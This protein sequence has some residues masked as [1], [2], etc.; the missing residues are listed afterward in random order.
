MSNTS[1]KEIT[2][3][4][5][6]CKVDPC[7]V[8]TFYYTNHKGKFGLRQ[9]E[10]KSLDWGVTAWFPGEPQW[11]LTAYDVGKA[12][13]RTFALSNVCGDVANTIEAIKRLGETARKAVADGCTC[14][15]LNGCLCDHPE[16][17]RRVDAEMNHAILVCKQKF[18]AGVRENVFPAETRPFHCGDCGARL[19][20]IGVAEV[21]EVACTQCGT[22]WLVGARRKG[23]ADLT[24]VWLP[25]MRAVANH[26]DT[27]VFASRLHEPGFATLRRIYEEF[28]K[29]PALA[30]VAPSF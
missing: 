10:P 15:I 2:L 11:H 14:D 13:D 29:L 22:V 25:V 12:A 30:R 9:V 3:S 7:K 18:T 17:L 26:I 21:A 1:K 24:D 6:D 4:V 28:T 23:Q 8:I 5:G 16:R 19:R 20:D 27:G